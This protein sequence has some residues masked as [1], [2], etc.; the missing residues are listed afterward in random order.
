MKSSLLGT[1]LV[2]VPILQHT[3]D[4][5]QPLGRLKTKSDFQAKAGKGRSSAN[6]QAALH[7]GVGMRRRR[8]AG[9]AAPLA[10]AEVGSSITD[11]CTAHLELKTLNQL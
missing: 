6:N 10:T 8:Y 2:T 4:L 5:S 1:G 11:I 7:Q 3:C 9:W